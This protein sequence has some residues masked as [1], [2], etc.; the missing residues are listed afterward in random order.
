MVEAHVFTIT[1]GFLMSRV[2][3]IFLWLFFLLIVLLVGAYFA[4]NS[5]LNSVTQKAMQ[6]LPKQAR[7]VG[8]KIE[9]PTFQKAKITG[10]NAATWNTI[11]AQLSFPKNQSFDKKRVFNLHIDQLSVWLAAGDAATVAIKDLEINSSL[12]SATKQAEVE[13]LNNSQQRIFFPYLECQ[14][15]WQLFDPKTSI[16]DNLPKIVELITNGDATMPMT[17]EGTIEFNLKNKPVILRL[18]VEEPGNQLK[19]DESDVKKIAGLFREKLTDAEIE[20]VAANPLRTPELLRIKDDA[21][22]SARK[23][24]VKDPTIPEDAYRHVLWS[25]LLTK[26]YGAEFAEQ[27][28]DA[29][30]QGDTGN[31]P[32]ER[33][34]DYN[35]NSLGRQ[36]AEQGLKRG[37]LLRKATKD[38]QVIREA[39]TE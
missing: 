4:A 29:H 14:L 16:E 30:E 5:M 6:T 20:L 21:E 32:A 22:S 12:P 1:T 7:K 33:D 11:D 36:Y 24:K 23:A 13:E 39:E 37:Q 19:L 38:P 34:M 2:K 3:K 15:D 9:D 25:Y 10:L 17:G 8:M 31:T 18:F 26:K 35:N 28:T 27:V